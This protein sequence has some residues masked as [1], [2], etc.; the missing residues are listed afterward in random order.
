M[1][2]WLIAL[3]FVSLFLGISGVASPA[4]WPASSAADGIA[5]NAQSLPPDCPDGYT[6]WV[7]FVG[8]ASTLDGEPLPVGVVVRAYNPTGTVAGCAE[9]SQNGYYLAAVYADDPDTPEQDGAGE[10]DR[11][12]FTVDHHQAVPRGPDPPV[13]TAS[14]PGGDGRADVELQAC[15]LPGDFDCDC[16]VTVADLMRQ[17]QNLGV[18]RGEAGYYPPYDRDSDEDVDAA[19]LDQTEEDWR[20]ACGG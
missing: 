6:D 10:G 15:T 14:P 16:Q 5:S 1:H 9:V 19:D 18:S 13:W 7:D 20:E 11:I 8:Q 2:R 17:G 4:R 12:A 3:A